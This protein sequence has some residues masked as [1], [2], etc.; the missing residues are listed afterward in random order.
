MN[1]ASRV[2]TW[3]RDRSRLA[4]VLAVGAV[5]SVLAAVPAATASAAGNPASAT[6]ST[7][8]PLTILTPSADSGGDDIFLAPVAPAGDGYASGPEIV[9]TTGKVAWFNPLPAGALAT[10]FRTQT[11][12]G[13]PVLTWFQDDDANGARGVV[14]NDRFQ[15]IATVHAGNGFGIRRARVP[16]HARR[17]PR[18][19]PPTASRRSTSGP[20]AA[21]L[22]RRS[23]SMWC[24]RS[25]SRPAGCCSSGTPPITCPT[26]T[27]TCRCRPRRA[28]SG[29]GSTSTPSTST[30]TATCWSARGTPGRSTR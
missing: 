30:R 6:G 13:Q 5:V 27:A 1:L 3:R 11:Y 14:Y 16:H 7:A 25:T 29:T 9:T 26:A 12:Q 21:R 18:S 17:T 24:R 19:S 23:R 8:P 28:K 15:Q 22:T 2:L 4:A 20:S 10:D